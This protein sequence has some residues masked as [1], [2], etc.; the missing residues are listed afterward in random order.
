MMGKLRVRTKSE[1]QAYQ[2]GF[3]A[4]VKL[5]ER[6]IREQLGF[7]KDMCTEW[8]DEEVQDATN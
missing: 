4:A 8:T 2:Q 6:R 7:A 5:L 1:R 3:A